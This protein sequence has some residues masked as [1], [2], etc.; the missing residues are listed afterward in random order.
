MIRYLIQITVIQVY[1]PTTNAKEAEVKR[2][3]GNLQD[4]V[5]LTPKK[6]RC[7]HHRGLKCQ[8]RVS[9]DT[10]NNRQVWPWSTK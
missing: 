7:F 3:Y 2:F 4:L 1:D 6:E 9:R 10:L 5:E 8:S